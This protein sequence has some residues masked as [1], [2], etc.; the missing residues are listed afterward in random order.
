MKER[1][2]SYKWWLPIFRWL[3]IDW[4]ISLWLLVVTVSCYDRTQ[5]QIWPLFPCNGY[6]SMII[7]KIIVYQQNNKLKNI[8]VHKNVLLFPGNQRQSSTSRELHLIFSKNQKKIIS[9]KPLRWSVF[10][11]WSSRR[12]HMV[13]LFRQSCGGFKAVL[14]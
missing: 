2:E 9:N 7:Q 13:L 3:I 5:H 8:S 6:S 12:L 1:R 10:S 11:G 4:K 14:P